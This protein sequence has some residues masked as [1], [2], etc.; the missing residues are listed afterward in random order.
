MGEKET[1]TGAGLV[2]TEQARSQ[3]EKMSS[4][5]MVQTEQARSQ[6]EKMST[7]GLRQTPKRDFGDRM[8]A[9]GLD[10]DAPDDPS[11]TGPIRLDPTP[12]R[13][14][15][16]MT[17]ERADETAD[18]VNQG[19]HAAG[20]ALSTGA[21]REAGGDDES[22]AVKKATSGLKDTLKTQV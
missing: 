16:N 19:L 12:A 17:I 5:G 20:S 2:Q 9:P 15:T 14:S 13:L 21:S 4:G 7:S 1:M 8:D 18:K 10:P 11:A 6:H 3:H 22:S